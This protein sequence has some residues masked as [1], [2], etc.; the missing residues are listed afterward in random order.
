MSTLATDLFSP[1]LLAGQPLR[2]LGLG[3]MNLNHAYSNFPDHH[4][5]VDFLIRAVTQAG[6]DHF[7]TAT[8]YGSGHNEELVGRALNTTTSTGRL[9]D[10]VFLASKCGLSNTADRRIDGRPDTLRAQLEASLD[11]LGTDFI[12]LYYLHRLDPEVPV[13][14]S[15]G[16]LSEFIAEGKIG[17]FGLSEVSAATLRRADAVHPVA[18]VQNEY[19]LWTRNPEWGLLDACKETGTVLI[20]F[21]PVARGFLTDVP[22]Q[23]QLKQLDEKDIRRAMPRFSEQNYPANLELHQ[24]LAELARQ[25]DTSVAALALGWVLAQSENIIAI[26]GTTSFEHLLQDLSATQLQLN[27]VDIRRIGDTIHHGN[28]SGHRYAASGR[29]AVDTEDQPA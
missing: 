13:E 27:P 25:H 3:C 28:V 4:D 6:I 15:V 11:R 19:S 8:L 20:A 21:S 5:A 12:D 1:R 7:D 17:A 22:P 14:E 29:V 10:H 18:A 26:P 23:P 16:V 2:P 24:R 9:R